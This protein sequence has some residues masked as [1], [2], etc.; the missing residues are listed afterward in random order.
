[1]GQVE[2][3]PTTTT[4]TTATPRDCTIDHEPGEPVF[5]SIEESDLVGASLQ[6]SR[7]YFSCA[8]EVV[9]A[10]ADDLAV[11]AV[12]AQLASA[13]ESTLL[14]HDPDS[15]TIVNAELTRLDPD[16]ITLVSLDGDWLAGH[17]AEIVHLAG[18]LTDLGDLARRAAGSIARVGLAGTGPDTIAAVLRS[19]ADGRTTTLPTRQSGVCDRDSQTA[20]EALEDA[21]AGRTAHGEVWLVDVCSPGL[22]LLASASLGSEGTVLLIDGRDLRRGRQLVTAL[23][24]PPSG[25]DQIHIAGEASEEADWQLET[26]LAGDELPGGGLLLFPGRRIVALYGNPTTR[27]LG[28]LGEQGVEEAIER[29]REVAEPYG[30]DGLEIL[31]GFEIIASVAS[32]SAGRDGDYSNEMSVDQLRPW[33]EA[34]G[35][36][37]VYVVLDLQSGRSDF[38]AQAKNYEELLLLPHV[39]LALDPEWRLKPNQVHLEQIGSV[40]AEEVNRVVDW[41]AGLVRDNSLPQKLFIVHQFRLDMVTNRSLI[42]KPPELA[43]MVHADGQGPIATKYTTY[44]TLTGRPDADQWWWGWKNFY[45]EDSPTPTPEQVLELD[46]L[47][48]YVSYQ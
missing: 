21:A 9:I 5:E 7:Q 36:G 6:L 28:V 47:P 46:P 10:P 23:H 45:D 42:N 33:V 39:G 14:L 38:L 4:S 25:I 8:D 35:D 43:M 31:P 19:I 17:S 48:V 12:A 27:F 16:R 20:A 15:S 2:P 29:A 22:A 24:A 11:V 37:G 44:S 30:A 13:T 32:V 40:G 41:L 26:L 3:S 18:P 34:A 1:M